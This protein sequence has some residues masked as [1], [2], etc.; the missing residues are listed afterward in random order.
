MQR[1]PKQL[2]K[3]GKRDIARISNIVLSKVVLQIFLNEAQRVF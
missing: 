1:K 3:S 2:L